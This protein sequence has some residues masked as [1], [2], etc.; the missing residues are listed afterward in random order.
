M[1]VTES[2]SNMMLTGPARLRKPDGQLL[3]VYLPGA[4][5]E[6][7]AESY[8]VLTTIRGKT[9]TRGLAS[10]SM[11]VP[12]KVV[13]GKVI[14]TRSMPVLSFLIGSPVPGQIGS[15]TCRE[16]GE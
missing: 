15:A 12:D 1:I 7:M 14:R 3:C 10:G 13:D 6:E 9:E 5:K 8:P 11:R 4:L 16:R 2:G